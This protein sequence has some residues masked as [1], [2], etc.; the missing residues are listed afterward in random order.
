MPGKYFTH[1]ETT[2]LRFD[3]ES[4]RAA[5]LMHP[6]SR[7]WADPAVIADEVQEF[8]PSVD[9]I[10]GQDMLGMPT[11]QFKTEEALKRF[12]DHFKIEDALDITNR[13]L[14]DEPDA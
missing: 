10:F 3:C 14:W 4:L 6:R 5:G 12:L 9:A 8:L 2:Y 7:V 1:G 11:F 13:T